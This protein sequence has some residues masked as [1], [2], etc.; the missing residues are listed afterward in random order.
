MPD[1][2]AA[3]RQRAGALDE[4]VIRELA[5]HLADSYAALLAEGIPREEAER[6]TLNQLSDAAALRWRLR[7]S[8]FGQVLWPGAV[9]GLVLFDWLL[10][11]GRSHG[12]L[13]GLVYLSGLLV[14]GAMAGAYA[15]HRHATL[16]ECCFGLLWPTLGMAVF[17]LY[18]RDPGPLS[19]WMFMLGGFLAGGLPAY[20]LPQFR[21]R[22]AA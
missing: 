21:R 11:F 22:R 5:E 9:A 12:A 7:P 6:R 13:G 15:R 8:R 4:G 3:L 20:L 18:A 14:A 2:A 10:W 16:R 19:S 1:W 17:G